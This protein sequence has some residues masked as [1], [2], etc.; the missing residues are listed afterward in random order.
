VTA[1]LRR[2]A[3]NAVKPSGEHISNVVSAID[4]RDAV[5]QLSNDRLV[6]TRI[7]EVAT[8]GRLARRRRITPTERILVLKQLAVMTRAGVDLLEA[9]QTIA[10]ALLPTTIA[11]GLREV[12]VRLRR[13]ERFAVALKTGVPSYPPYVYALVEAGEASG[14][15]FHVLH[16]AAQQLSV[17]HR[18]R[19]EMRNALIYPTFLVSAG[20]LA[21]A[22]LLLVV[23]PRFAT[24][25]GERRA[26]LDG[27]SALVL[28]LGVGFRD[29]LVLVI[30]MMIMVGIG[31][32]TAAARPQ[33]RRALRWALDH[34]PVVRGLI[35]LRQ[36][37]AWARIMSLAVGS[38]VGLL[39]A[40]EL[41]LIGVPEGR[42][43]QGLLS[44]FGALRAGKPVADA[45]GSTG[46]LAPVDLSL[47]RAGQRSGALAEMFDAI[48]TAYDE[49]LT[50]QLKR[51]VILTEQLAIAVVALAIGAV[52][53][54]L[55]SALTGIYDTIG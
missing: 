38:G 34:V 8:P 35:M 51:V 17:E 32:F 33:G 23:V 4:I 27:L 21:V 9:L 43:R 3:Y 15:L 55:V 22:F 19:R 47:L 20:T 45:F 36:R 24:M 39:P 10:S 13:G 50:D 11:L 29:H 30:G 18:M 48:A 40:A 5:R 16:E 1:D 53:I 6:V 46:T 54:G 44:A 37:A 42:F 12:A 28:D 14:Q 31:L 52:V 25:I 49:H 2:Y 26:E 7:D 41:A